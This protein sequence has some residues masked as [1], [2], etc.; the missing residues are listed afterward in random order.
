[1]GQE[2]V[3]FHKQ[4][5]TISLTFTRHSVITADLFTNGIVSYLDGQKT[6]IKGI[7]EPLIIDEASNIQVK[8]NV[9]CL[10]SIMAL[11]EG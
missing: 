10:L 3:V 9:L 5:L 8:T 2:Y 6:C 7:C 4:P 11:R 1:M